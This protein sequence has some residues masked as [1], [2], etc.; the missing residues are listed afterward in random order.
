MYDTENEKVFLDLLPNNGTRHLLVTVEEDPTVKYVRE[1]SHPSGLK[2][3]KETNILDDDE[4][5]KKKSK[6]T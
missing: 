1:E 5:R 3:R 2:E 6:R 4:K